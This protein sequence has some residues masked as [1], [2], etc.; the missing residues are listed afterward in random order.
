MNILLKILV[1]TGLPAR[2]YQNCVQV[3]LNGET[4]TFKIV[5]DL[6]VAD[7]TPGFATLVA[8]KSR[9]LDYLLSK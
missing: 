7:A 9:Q 5:G 3:S 4:C 6:L 2:F 1:E 8:G